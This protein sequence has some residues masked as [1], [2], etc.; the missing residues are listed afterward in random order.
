M[1]K[2]IGILLALL[3]GWIAGGNVPRHQSLMRA[4]SVSIFLVTTRLHWTVNLTSILSLNAARHAASFPSIFEVN[5]LYSQ[6]SHCRTPLQCP[7]SS[8]TGGFGWK[9]LCEQQTKYRRLQTYC[10]AWLCQ[11]GYKWATSSWTGS[12]YAQ[13]QNCHSIYCQKYRN[14]TT[15]GSPYTPDTTD[16]ARA[17]KAHTHRWASLNIMPWSSSLHIL[18]FTSANSRLSRFITTS[19]TTP[20]TEAKQILPQVLYYDLSLNGFGIWWW[21]I[22]F[23]HQWQLSRFLHRICSIWRGCCTV[24]WGKGISKEIPID[25]Q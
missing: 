9:R 23:Y 21:H 2:M 13:R 6:C 3:K 22:L 7:P 16:S 20:S 24:F 18:I 12:N 10:P 15:T 5:W 4:R 14:R 17:N 25:K 8:W 11:P 19:S 1:V